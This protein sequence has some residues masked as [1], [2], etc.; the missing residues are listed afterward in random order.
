MKH[1]NKELVVCLF[2]Y[3]APYKTAIGISLF[4]MIVVA[5]FE[6]MVPALLTPLIDENLVKNTNDNAWKI[7][8][9][10]IIVFI[11]KG[12][13]EYLA[14]VSSQWIANKAISEIRQDV[15]NHQI[16]LPIQTNRE[17]ALGRITSR[18][19]YDIPQISA[20]ISSAWIIIIRDSLVLITLTG[21]LIFVSWPL[22]II[23]LI[24]APPIAYLIN[25]VGVKMRSSNIEIQNATGNLA[26]SIDQ[27]IVGIKEIKLY[28]HELNQKKS[29]GKVSEH[30]RKKT[31]D[32][33]KLS[34]ANVPT[35]QFLAALAVT[36]V[37]YVA[38]LLSKQNELTPGQ[39]VSFI[40]AMSLLFEPIRRLTSVN[41]VIQKGLAAS[42]SIF[43]LLSLEEENQTQSSTTNINNNFFKILDKS[44]PLIM[45]KNVFFKYPNQ[46]DF[47]LNGISFNVYQNESLG[48]VGISGSG[49]STVINLLTGFY[50]KIDGSILINSKNI[51]EIPLKILR[52]KF[53]WVGQPIILFDDTIRANILVGKSDA[54]DKEI[55]NALEKS[56]SHDFVR[57]LDKQLDF[58]IGA[59]GTFL[60]SGQCQRIAIARAIIRNAPI[61]LFDEATS[62]LDSQSEKII[63]ESLQKIKKN[64]TVITIAHR[65][66]TVKD[67]DRILVFESGKIV[68][69]GSHEELVLKDGVYKNL[70]NG[71]NKKTII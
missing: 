56:N 54:N 37:I 57:S 20:S 66:S 38:T 51:E 40:A 12:L 6:P 31:M 23:M 22:T 69:V 58:N 59:N 19:L 28:G 29:F 11:F 41:A 45:F 30:I 67:C 1:N 5:A 71:T 65:I 52:K 34:A 16:L 63:Q 42:K 61:F 60:S 7:P 3:I 50:K 32:I 36:V 10:L 49:K 17:E 53:S 26:K 14:N 44:K 68:Q 25:K 46:K 21:Y 47:A 9:L 39:F 13:A 64:K 48:I 62:A 27:S 43:T 35:V 15:F 33:V 24:V 18:F 55:F 2:G 70:V 8:L 4:A